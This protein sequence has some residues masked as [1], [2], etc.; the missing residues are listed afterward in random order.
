MNEGKE[1]I[2][3]QYNSLINKLKIAKNEI[4]GFESSETKFKQIQNSFKDQLDDMIYNTEYKLHEVQSNIIW[5]KLVIAFFGETNAGKSTIIETLRILFSNKE[6]G[7]D[8]IIVGDGRSDFTK[9]YAKYNLTIDGYPITLIDV[10]GIEGREEDYKN[11]IKDAL[12]KAHCVF[13]IQGHNKEPDTETATK[14]KQYLNDWVKVY[15][16]YNSRGGAEN[17]D[18]EDERE[19]LYTEKVNQQTKL[20]TQSFERILGNCYQGNITIQALIAMCAYAQFAPDR[21]DLAKQ[22][23][24]MLLYFGS[25]ENAYNFS[26]FQDIVKLLNDLSSNYKKNIQDAAT[27]K[28]KA[29]LNDIVENLRIC[30]KDNR[31]LID[32]LVNQL[33]KFRNSV[34]AETTK[35]NSSTKQLLYNTIDREFNEVISSLCQ[36]VDNEDDNLKSLAKKKS[37]KLSN[38][39]SRSLPLI[40]DNKLKELSDRITNLKKDLDKNLAINLNSRISHS[41]TEL[42]IKSDQVVKELDFKFADAFDI[43]GFVLSG[44]TI[45]SYFTWLAPGVATAI[46]AVVGGII[47][48]VKYF[49]LNKKEKKA[50]AKAAIQKELDTVKSKVKSDVITAL[51]KVFS[52]IDQDKRKLS[53]EIGRDIANLNDIKMELENLYDKLQKIK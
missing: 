25:A 34:Q 45:G 5:D 53:S 24:L 50:K 1:Y 27:R 23:K 2:D 20:N 32:L 33:N 21:S 48:T 11:E 51:H 6:K 12:L 31:E 26:R 18:E 42:N 8:G 36:A 16:I 47:G 41:K 39:L 19:N 49:F 46:G 7:M 37:E 14:I 9:V 29:C 44:A 22:Q 40:V 38:N 17:Y 15:S 3:R 28:F 13:Y 52:K 35:F 30:Y 43:G 10:P 4:E